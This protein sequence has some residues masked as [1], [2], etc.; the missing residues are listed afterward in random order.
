MKLIDTLKVL[1]FVATLTLG[2]CT[3]PGPFSD[4]ARV[5]DDATETI[6]K[7]TA[8]HTEQFTINDAL[9]PVFTV[10]EL[11]AVGQK[12]YIRTSCV[13]FADGRVAWEL[14]QTK[15]DTAYVKG[16]V[17]IAKVAPILNNAI[18][19]MIALATNGSLPIIDEIFQLPSDLPYELKR[20]IEG[21]SA[22][23]LEHFSHFLKRNEYQAWNPR[24][25]DIAVVAKANDDWYVLK[26]SWHIEKGA[27][28]IDP[29]RL[30]KAK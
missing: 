29:A 25:D 2:S 5:V 3:R 1:P 6:I 17:E 4:L 19:K 16:N 28:K 11:E 8:I 9:E 30:I 24:I 21:V 18:H 23:N 27:L 26:T 20:R 14:L 13:V 7:N 12:A 15:S 22:T 10:V